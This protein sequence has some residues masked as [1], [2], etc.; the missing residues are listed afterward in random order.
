MHPKMLSA[1]IHT[2]SA[3]AE[4]PSDGYVTRDTAF[5]G[6]GVSRKKIKSKRRKAVMKKA[7][8]K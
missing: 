6:G 5:P 7:K 8:R 3:V 1:M 2:L 4:I